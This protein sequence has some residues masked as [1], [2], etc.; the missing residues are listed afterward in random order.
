MRSLLSN[1]LFSYTLLAILILLLLTGL[2]FLNIYLKNNNLLIHATGT[3]HKAFLNST[4]K[5]SKNEVERANETKFN[6]S[7][8]SVG[9]IIDCIFN[10][11]LPENY[12]IK[13]NISSCYFGRVYFFGNLSDITYYFFENELYQYSLNTQVY[14]F[15][16]VDYILKALKQKFGDQYSEDIQSEQTYYLEWETANENVTF[17][18]NFPKNSLK[19]DYYKF[20]DK[21]QSATVLISV[22]YLPMIKVIEDKIQKSYDS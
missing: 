10:K 1:K 6:D 9:E 20:T 19:E 16:D 14:G 5:M 17:S 11:G 21:D 15:S 22:T 2:Y 8:T 4:W 18:L 3:N 7:K 12:N 13:D